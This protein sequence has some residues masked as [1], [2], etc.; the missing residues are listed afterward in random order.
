M[1]DL[2]DLVPPLELCKLIPTGEFADSALMWL[3]VDI[4]QG[5][6]TGWQ[7]IPS[8]KIFRTCHNPKYPAPTLQE[9]MEAIGG[10]KEEFVPDP[11]SP[12]NEKLIKRNPQYQPSIEFFPEANFPW[13]SMR[14]TNSIWSE[15]DTSAPEAA[16]RTYLKVK[17]VKVTM[18]CVECGTWLQHLGDDQYTEEFFDNIRV[19]VTE[20]CPKCGYKY[21]DGFLLHIFQDI[22]KHLIWV[23]TPMG[24]RWIKNSPPR[25]TCPIQN[26]KGKKNAN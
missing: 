8:Y 21:Y 11:L 19:P 6:K 5:D 25:P 9:I 24:S 26:K 22:E 3:E 4:P 20:V 1:S 15:S 23:N 14:W 10:I 2:T 7:V 18:P 16:I 13:T 12:D 17:G